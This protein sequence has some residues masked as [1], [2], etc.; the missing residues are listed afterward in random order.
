MAFLVEQESSQETVPVAIKPTP[1]FCI[2][3][4]TSDSG[5]YT[6]RNATPNNSAIT[7]LSALSPQISSSSSSP[8]PNPN[9]LPIPKG[10]KVFLNIAWDSNVPAPPPADEAAVRRAMAGGD[11]D[12]TISGRYYVPVV[13][14]E[15]RTVTDKAGKPSLVFDCVFSASLKSRCMKD[16]EFRLYLIGT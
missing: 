7:A 10:I 12:D 16:K 5:S 2:K 1:G 11:L 15:P 8:N 9:L 3:S 4:T 13:V 14:S 6:Y